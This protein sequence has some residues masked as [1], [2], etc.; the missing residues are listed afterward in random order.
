MTM[1]KAGVLPRLF[2]L[3]MVFTL[4]FGVLSPVASVYA[5]PE[6]V[7]DDYVSVTKGE[8]GKPDS[9][10]IK[11]SEDG[12]SLQMGD[13]VNKYKGVAVVITSILTITM[14]IFMLIQFT[15]LGASGD[16]DSARRKA[17][18]GILTTGI[19]TALFGGASIIIGFFWNFLAGV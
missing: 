3:L 16:N 4:C 17:I 2:A 1:F 18:T 10:T 7:F 15:K 9:V 6:G 11:T 8:E 13:V 19:A 12:K 14:F 5:G